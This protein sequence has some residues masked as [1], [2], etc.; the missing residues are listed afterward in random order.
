MGHGDNEH[1]RQDTELKLHRAGYY[2][3]ILSFGEEEAVRETK[4]AGANGFIVVD[5][6]P[7]E[8]IKFRGICTAEG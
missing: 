7:E 2:N 5:L 4:L 6:P 3:P 1:G 8:A